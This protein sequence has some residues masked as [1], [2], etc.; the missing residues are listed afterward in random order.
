MSAFSDLYMLSSM[1]GMIESEGREVGKVCIKSY[2]EEVA[3]A[4]VVNT[5]KG[6]LSLVDT[7]GIQTT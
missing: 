3:M 7:L 1:S 5:I 4:I 2:L 6:L